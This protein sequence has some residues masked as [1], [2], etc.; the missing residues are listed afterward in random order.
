ME[1]IEPQK[2][3]PFNNAF[4]VFSQSDVHLKTKN[5]QKTSSIK[6]NI[7]HK[8]KAFHFKELLDLLDNSHCSVTCFRRF[9]KKGFLFFL[10]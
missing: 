6:S 4:F 5:K 9:N 1:G 8:R 3:M 7:I 2:G 10:S